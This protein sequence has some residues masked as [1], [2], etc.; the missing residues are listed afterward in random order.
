MFKYFNGTIDELLEKTENLPK[1]QV[2]RIGDEN[3]QLDHDEIVAFIMD[4]RKIPKEEAEE[5]ATQFQMEEFHS[6]AGKMV[7]DGLLEVV[8]YDADG[9][10]YRPTQ[11]GMILAN[12]T[13]E[14]KI[15][16]N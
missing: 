16:L 3:T 1:S 7:D 14:N 12:E 9:P 5:I 8:G 6:I 2:D 15:H 10:I 4:E 11:K 13:S